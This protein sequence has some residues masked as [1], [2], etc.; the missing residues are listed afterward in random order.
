MSHVSDADLVLY[1]HGDAPDRGRIEAHLA[2]CD[3]C[4]TE[5]DI[6]SRVLALVEADIAP[7]PEPSYGVTVWNA[8]EARLDAAPTRAAF[9][10]PTSWRGWLRL[11]APPA[12]F[13]GAMAALLLVVFGGPAPVSRDVSREAVLRA[14]VEDHLERTGLMLTELNNAQ[15]AEDVED[16]H[17]VA[18]D[19]ASTNRLYRQSAA[20]SGDERIGRLLDD[21]ERVLLEVAHTPDSSTAD[22]ARPDAN[23][24]EALR[25]RLDTRGVAFRLRLASAELR[26]RDAAADATAANAGL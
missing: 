12:A 15:G 20:L 14:A 13:A 7:E 5:L 22:G 4:R 2:A 9:E 26:T 16:V 3:R 8:I 1:R 19:L 25:A 23:D 11:S 24:I 6:L 17:L 21:L 10:W 18:E